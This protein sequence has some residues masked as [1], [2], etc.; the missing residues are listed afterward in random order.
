MVLSLLATWFIGLL[1]IPSGLY[2]LRT[3]RYMSASPGAQYPLRQPRAFP[4]RIPKTEFHMTVEHGPSVR[5][6][7]QN[8]ALFG[9]LMLILF[10]MSL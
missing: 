9:G 1:L 3:G 10:A 4:R 5:Q 2:F 8:M 6:H 7:G